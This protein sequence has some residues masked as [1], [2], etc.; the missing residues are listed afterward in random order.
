MFL[1]HRSRQSSSK[2][3]RNWCKPAEE[4]STDDGPAKLSAPLA[5]SSKYAA[6]AAPIS[7]SPSH[8][9][10]SST[11]SEPKVKQ[12]AKTKGLT[13]SSSLTSSVDDVDDDELA[14][15]RHHHLATP[16][17]DLAVAIPSTKKFSPSLQMPLSF[18]RLQ[19]KLEATDNVLCLR[20]QF[21]GSLSQ[22][23]EGVQRMT[24]K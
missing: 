22:V 9:S 15:T 1:F 21:A 14:S 19:E 5:A 24:H 12:A 23:K 16:F 3:E 20:R 13:T 17:G 18:K 8:S 4:K 10:L 7:A 11:S 6:M 2:A